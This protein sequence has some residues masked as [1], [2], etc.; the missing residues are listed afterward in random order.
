LDEL[1][2]QPKNQMSTFQFASLALNKFQHAKKVKLPK[3]L[4][5]YINSPEEKTFFNEIYPKGVKNVTALSFP[6]SMDSL[7][8]NEN[9]RGIIPHSL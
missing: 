4:Y 3:S 7:A 2:L 6:A 9:A 1:D 8:R 5:S